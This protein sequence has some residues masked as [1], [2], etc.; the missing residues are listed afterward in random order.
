MKN[1]NGY[2]SIT[3]LSGKRRNPYIVKKTTGYDERAYPIYEIIG[4]YPSRKD[5]MM[6]LA[7][8]NADPY[9]VKL[10]K[11]TFAEVYEMLKEQRFPKMSKSLQQQHRASYNYCSDLYDMKYTDIRQYHFQKIIDECEN[12]SYSTQTCVKNLFRTMDKFAFDMEIIDKMRST[13]LT[14]KKTE[15][16]LK[17]ELFT[18]D[19]ILSLYSHAGERFVDETIFML[20]TGFRV[21]E[22]LKMRNTDIDLENGILRGGM[23]TA[24]GTNRIVPIH[25]KLYPIIQKNMSDAEYLFPNQNPD[26]FRK[27]WIKKLESLGMDHK[28]HDCRHTFRTEI[29]GANKVCI[30]MIMGHKTADVGE[31]IYTHKTIEQLKE[32]INF[33]T[34]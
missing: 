16:K 21:S 3:K 7:K 23:K 26:T 11:S 12:K 22:A 27:G 34:Y 18:R 17:R 29:D 31:R 5:A 33:I 10:A 1:P 20:Y 6:A 14:V 8:Y 9:D 25:P 32:A 30:D 19:E 28:T 13:N 4:Y 15:T 24:A 2:G